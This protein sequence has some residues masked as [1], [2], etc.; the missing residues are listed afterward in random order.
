MHRISKST[1][2]GGPASALVCWVLAGALSLTGGLL[3]VAPAMAAGPEPVAQCD[4]PENFGG[5]AQLRV[6]QQRG[7]ALVEVTKPGTAGRKLEVEYGDELYSQK[8]GADGSIRLGF[9]LTAQEN[10]FTLT[11]SEISP[12]TCTVMVPDMN[13]IFRVI[14]R[15]HDPVQF[16]LNVLEPGGRMGEVGNVSGGR[17]NTARKDG[18]GQMDIVGGVPAEDATGEMSYVADAATVPPDGVFGFRLDY[19]TRGS[20]PEAP[21]CDDNVLATPRID[22]IRIEGGKVTAQ[23]LS[24]N[25]ARCREK[26]PESRRLMMIR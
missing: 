16:D 2:L 18:I 23:R 1:A 3:L 19:V 7:R 11:M 14:L 26:I 10:R 20:Q 21:Y 15:W 6:S 5:D 25:R 8:F 9:A 22:F 17:P 4:R 12:V 13:K 24:M